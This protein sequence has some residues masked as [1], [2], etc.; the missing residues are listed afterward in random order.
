M[1]P[2][3]R[4]TFIVANEGPPPIFLS[5]SPRV[6]YFTVVLE[7]ERAKTFDT[8]EEADDALAQHVQHTS[9]H[10]H[11]APGGWRVYRMKTRATFEAL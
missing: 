10:I 2:I 8:R 1:K 3:T 5:R 11:S 4:E 6:A 7:I 9:G